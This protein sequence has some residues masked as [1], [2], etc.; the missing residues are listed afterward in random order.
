GR[1]AAWRRGRGR[2]IP[3]APGARST[4]TSWRRREV[5]PRARPLQRARRMP[6]LLPSR[7]SLRRSS[8]SV[9][10]ACLSLSHGEHRT[11]YGGSHPS[12]GKRTHR[13]HVGGDIVS[14]GQR[15]VART[16]ARG[17]TKKPPRREPRRLER[18]HREE[19]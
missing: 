1:E 6:R 17:E 12:V 3:A 11:R 10:G 14:Y 7:S 16:P 5:A 15:E 9:S 13:S 8:A 4:T 18:F 2:E 19:A